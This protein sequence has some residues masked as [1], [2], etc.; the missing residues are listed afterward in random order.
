MTGLQQR[1]LLAA[2]NYNRNQRNEEAR[3]ARDRTAAELKLMTE[4]VTALNHLF[5]Q[6]VSVRIVAKFDGYQSVLAVSDP[7]L[8][9]EGEQASSR[10]AKKQVTG[11]S[12]EPDKKPVE[13]NKG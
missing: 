4:Y 1:N 9:P 8:K 3:K 5:E 12:D 7:T 6:P 11:K 13:A 2:Q 10:P